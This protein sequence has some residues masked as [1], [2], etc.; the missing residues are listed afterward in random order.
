MS[1]I[2]LFFISL[3]ALKI[4]SSKRYARPAQTLAHLNSSHALIPTIN[5]A[6]ADTPQD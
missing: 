2:Q 3:S 4:G 5:F 6:S 1:Y